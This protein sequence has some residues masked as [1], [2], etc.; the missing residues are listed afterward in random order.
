LR[1]YGANAGTPLPV[2]EL[3]ARVDGG[4]AGAHTVAISEPQA[5]QAPDEPQAD[6]VSSECLTN[7][8]TGDEGAWREALIPGDFE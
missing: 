2:N 3:F 4:E 8:S 5:R 6:C 1:G 7:T